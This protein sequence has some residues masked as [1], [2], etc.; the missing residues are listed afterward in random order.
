MQK[1]SIWNISVL[2][3]AALTGVGYSSGQE[4]YQFFAFYGKY[5]LITALLAP[6]LLCGMSFLYIMTARRK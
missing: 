5:G 2:F 3:V 1:Y 4:V 6:I